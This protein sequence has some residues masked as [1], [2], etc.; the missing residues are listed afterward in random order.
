MIDENMIVI[1]DYETGDFVFIN[2]DLVLDPS[3]LAIDITRDGPPDWVIKHATW[4]IGSF[5]FSIEEDYYL[6]VKF[7]NPI[8]CDLAL[9]T[10]Q[11]ADKY[12]LL[13][14]MNKNV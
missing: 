12:K 8:D 10:G 7:Q 4:I 9:Y 13:R 14:R 3:V 11:V 6:F 2:V 5:R 1:D